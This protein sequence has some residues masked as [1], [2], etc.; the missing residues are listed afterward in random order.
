MP[1]CGT[2]SYPW[3]RIN[4]MRQGRGLL[5]LIAVPALVSLAVTL[6]VLSLMGTPSVGG[7]QVVVLPTYSGTAQIPPRSTQPIP[8]QTEAVSGGETGG[9]GATEAAGGCEN[10]VHIVTGGET[11]GS[12][13]EQYGVTT[14]DITSMNQL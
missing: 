13:A 11:L 12:I 5:V 4:R 9:G 3:A 6:L 1:L 7:P 14:D 8:G 10:P 2:V